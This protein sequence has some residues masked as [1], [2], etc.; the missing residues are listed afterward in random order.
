WVS[1]ND[2]LIP[3]ALAI[4]LALPVFAGFGLYRIVFRHAGADA[5]VSSAAACAVYG[6]AYSALITAYSFDDVPRTLGII[7]PILLFLVVAASRVLG[8]RIFNHR[9]TGAEANRGR[10]PVLIYGAGVTGRQLA[11]A[12]ATSREMKVVG[13]V[14]DDRSLHNSKIGSLRV[15]DPAVLGP[16]VERL[17]VR[18]VL[19]AIPS[20]SRSRRREIIERL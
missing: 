15:Y 13:F 12:L 3:V 6:L 8:E 17:G 10:T 16:S 4:G 14:D 20:T 7:Q 1:L 18:E 2:H 19:L 11:Q 5:V 9:R